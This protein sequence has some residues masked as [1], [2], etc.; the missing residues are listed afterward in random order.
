MVAYIVV[1]I[2]K[3]LNKMKCNYFVYRAVKRSYILTYPIGY[4]GL[5]I[6]LPESIP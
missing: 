2:A 4:R 6:Q 5:F 3:I 1:F